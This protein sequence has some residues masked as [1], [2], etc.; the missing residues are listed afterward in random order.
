MAIIKKSNIRRMER[1]QQLR[2]FT[3]PPKDPRY[4]S[5]C[6]HGG[7]QIVCNSS[8]RSQHHLLVSMDT[9]YTHGLLECRQLKQPTHK[10]K[11]I[12]YVI[13]LISEGNILK[14]CHRL[15]VGIGSWRKSTRYTNPYPN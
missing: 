3:I 4:N 5:Q 6:P 1:A 9:M 12:H 14:A 2:S 8:Q 10:N 15:R 7:S 11:Q 13:N